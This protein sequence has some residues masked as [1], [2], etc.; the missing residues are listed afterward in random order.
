MLD[1]AAK[2]GMY[3]EL[4]ELFLG[5]PDTFPKQFHDRFEV[6][7][8]SG[9]LA[10]GH[11]DN[12]VFDE[13]LLALKKGGYACFSTRTMYL[14]QYSYGDKIKALEEEGKW[15]LVKEITFERYDKLEEEVG[16]FKKVEVKG[17]AYKKL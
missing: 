2:K 4:H 10:E 3:T 14:T 17:F 11:L 13:M 9:I 8:A 12:R 5:T 1:K 7:T 15:E 16:R 6:L